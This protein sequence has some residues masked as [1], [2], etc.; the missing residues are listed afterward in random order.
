MSDADTKK[1]RP[2]K[3]AFRGSAGVDPLTKKR[4]RRQF[5]SKAALLEWKFDAKKSDVSDVK[6]MTLEELGNKY[7]KDR[8][9]QGRERATWEKYEEHFRLHICAIS[10]DDGPLKGQ[11]LQHAQVALLKPSHM[12]ELRN[13]LVKTRSHAM[14]L[15]VWSTL[16][17]ALDFA[18]VLE[19]R[20]DNPA[21]AL[22]IEKKKRA[23][24]PI[25]E[26]GAI[27]SKEDIGIIFQALTADISQPTFGQV[28]IL[29]TMM[30]GMR[31][32]ESRGIEWHGYD[33]EEK[34]EADISQRAD[35]Y[36][37]IGLPKTQA[38]YR[39]IPLPEMLVRVLKRWKLACPKVEGCN[40]VF[41]TSNGTPFNPANFHNRVWVP[42]QHALGLTKQK[43]DKKGNK[44][45]VQ[46]PATGKRVPKMVHRYTLYSLRHAY[47]SLQIDLGISEKALQERMGHESIAMTMDIY[48]HLWKNREK[49]RADMKAVDGWFRGLPVSA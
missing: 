22:R 10:I 26:D 13:I 19:I 2:R 16:C 40:L 14:A 32:S 18:T 38:G 12:L 41:P 36:G 23:K 49:D 1:G 31:P 28:Y 21:R 17:A 47:A 7:V 4:R 3:K 35:A 33:L 5:K 43:V 46:D 24:K 6:E 34:L 30:T 37:A 44:V 48:G 20:L 39:Q 15:K 25:Q 11:T 29:N 9:A 42:L 45:F 27:P 8:E